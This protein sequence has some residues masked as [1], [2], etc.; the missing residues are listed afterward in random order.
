[1]SNYSHARNSTSNVFNQLSSIRFSY[2]NVAVMIVMIGILTI[3]VAGNT[4]VIYIFGIKSRKQITR[5][6]RFLLVLGLID[7]I[8]SFMIP[9]SFLYLT[10]TDF[11]DWHFGYGGCKVIP[12]L[13][14]VSVTISQGVLIAISYERYHTLVNPFNDKLS[15]YKLATWA[16]FVLLMAFV[17]VAPYM[18][19]MKVH[20]DQYYRKKTCAPDNNMYDII[21]LSASLNLFRDIVALCIMSFIGYRINQALIKQHD[22]LTWEREKMSR[23]GRK[24]LRMVIIVF[25]VLTIPVDLFQVVYYA[26]ILSG[27]SISPECFNIIVSVNTILNI[28]QTANSVVNVFIYSRVHQTF[29]LSSCEIWKKRRPR[30]QSFADTEMCELCSS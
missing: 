17:L 20:E 23:K 13:L 21:M 24:I 18:E 29:R 30:S 9:L 19:T 5:F 8:S 2:L 28:V 15:K 16:S 7:W 6:E 11:R 14:Q 25:A 10:V 4:L 3:G 26:V 22:K 12:S 27:I 1:M